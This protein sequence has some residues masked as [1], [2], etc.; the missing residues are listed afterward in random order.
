MA[1]MISID[2]DAGGEA[3]TPCLLHGEHATLFTQPGSGR[4]AIARAAASVTE[5]H[6]G[7][8]GWVALPPSHG[9][10]WDTPPWDY[11]TGRPM[12][13]PHGCDIRPHLLGAARQILGSITRGGPACP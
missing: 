5:L 1:L 11:R 9:A 2:G 12:P 6:T 10:R 7:S 8:A 3:A 13:L 4:Q